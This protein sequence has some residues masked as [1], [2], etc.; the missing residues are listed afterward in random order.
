[1]D[2]AENGLLLR[3]DFHTLLDRGYITIDKNL[4]IEVSY[5]IKEDFGNGK[6]YYA[7]YGKKLII[8]LERKDQLP[9]SNYLEWHN[10]NIFRMSY[11]KSQSIAL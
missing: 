8:L 9:D 11:R 5:K 2:L 4:I 1:M 3:S 7:H 6:E 10:E